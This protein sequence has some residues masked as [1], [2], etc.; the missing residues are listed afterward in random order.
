VTGASDRPA[1]LR[2]VTWN[3]RAG[4]G[5][6][7]PFPPAWWRHVRRERLARIAAIL[8]ELEP[9]VAT[10]QE[11]AILTPHGELLDEPAELARLTG[12]SV[13]YASVHA[14]PLVE[15]ETGRSIGMASWG[16][17][18][19]TRSPLEDG[20]ALGLPRAGDDDPVEVPGA[21]DPVTGAPHPL[22]GVRYGDAEPGHREPRCAVGGRVGGVTV[23]TT[24]LTYIG[25][26]QRRRQAD[27]LRGAIDHRPGP[28][29]LT[30]DFNAATD[31][32]ELTS[33][34]Q[35]LDEAF[36]AVG[37]AAGDPARASCGPWPI[38][39]VRVRGLAVEAC[40]VATEADDVS[41]HWPVVAD[42]ETV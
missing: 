7:E 14:F 30:G 29:V 35:G 34:E 17:A 1:R 37:V 24:H 6:G 20:F 25:R 11:V 40:R 39:H 8:D 15:P 13:R 22:V 9:D 41:D 26:D 31:A 21:L 23:V 38:D 5:P 12:R 42:L 32:P 19:L 28:L 4:I 10:L 16:N 36:A 2:V 3:I 27:A 33:L 18:I